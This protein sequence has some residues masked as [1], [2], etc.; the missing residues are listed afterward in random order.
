MPSISSSAGIDAAIYK[1]MVNPK[2][3]NILGVDVNTINKRE[4]L[5][6]VHIWAGENKP[7]S[8]SY[9]NA[10]CVNVAYVDPVY[11]AALNKMDL[12]YADG[13][14]VVMAGGFLSGS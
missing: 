4:L 2:T 3:I 1:L 9:V 14:G 7:R 6:L 5:E 11:R 8:I 13:G 12:V 10:H